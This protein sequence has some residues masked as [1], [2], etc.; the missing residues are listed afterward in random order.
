M[1]TRARA[2]RLRL[3]PWALAVAVW[4][5]C[6]WTAVA[7]EVGTTEVIATLN[8]GRYVVELTLNPEALLAK[9]DATSGRPR[10][11]RL[12]PTEYPG[13]LQRRAGEI[14]QAVD[15]RFDD[16]Q[17]TSTLESVSD[18]TASSIEVSEESVASPRA[19]IRLTGAVPK[20]ARAFR[21]SYDLTFATYS[22]IV[23]RAG[24]PE[25]RGEWLEGGQSSTPFELGRGGFARRKGTGFIQPGPTALVVCAAMMTALAFRKWPRNRPSPRT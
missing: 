15:V 20:G 22:F 21:W 1:S 19:R 7:H 14:L 10:A 16:R 6:P 25:G 24:S 12:A 3:A 4:I 11:A 5:A 9:L 13:A 23:K 17:V 2:T 18:V 8:S